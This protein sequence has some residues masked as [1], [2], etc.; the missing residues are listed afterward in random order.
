MYV[1]FYFEFMVIFFN[2][3]RVIIGMFLSKIFID[4]NLD[5]N[6][7]ISWGSVC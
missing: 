3:Y 7:F 2:I 1:F 5:F 4:E 6:L